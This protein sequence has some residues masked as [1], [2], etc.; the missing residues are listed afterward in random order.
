MNPWSP[1][2][3]SSS[4]KECN[5]VRC[6][7]CG[8]KH[9]VANKYLG[10]CNEKQTRNVIAWRN[11]SRYIPRDLEY[12]LSAGVG[13][14]FLLAHA[15]QRKLMEVNRIVI[16]FLYKFLATILAVLMVEYEGMTVVFS[17][18]SL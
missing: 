5:Q 2:E 10:T 9:Q 11:V 18:R 17:V 4:A 6:L 13:K 12:V 16:S 14:L 7:L 3:L 1:S 8:I 15:I